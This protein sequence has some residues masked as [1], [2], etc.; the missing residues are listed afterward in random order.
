MWRLA[1][2]HCCST[3]RSEMP[4][5]TSLHIES[6]WRTGMHGFRW[7]LSPTSFTNAALTKPDCSCATQLHVPCIWLLQTR[8]LCSTMCMYCHS[9]APL[10]LQSYFDM[11]G[12]FYERGVDLLYLTYG[13]YVSNSLLDACQHEYLLGNSVAASDCNCLYEHAMLKMWQSCAC[14]WSELLECSSVESCRPESSSLDISVSK[15]VDYLQKQNL[16]AR[17]YT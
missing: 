3:I 13:H 11:C 7:P 9:H 5:T 10:I 8:G 15:V 2:L 17:Q 1:W 16:D 12:F 4:P 14:A 6:M